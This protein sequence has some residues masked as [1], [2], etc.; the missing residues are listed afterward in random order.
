[1]PKGTF[2]FSNLATP[3]FVFDQAAL[4][5]IVSL[6]NS[7]AEYSNVKVLYS[8]KASVAS[9]VLESVL[10][11]IH[12]V[13]CSSVFE[14]NLLTTMNAEKAIQ[15]ISP[16]LTKAF[17]NSL[18][19]QPDLLTFNSIEQFNRLV[20]STSK[21]TRHAIRV[22]P[23]TQFVKN[24]KYDPCRFGSKLGVN[25]EKIIKEFQHNDSFRDRI[26]GLHVHNNCESADFEQLRETVEILKP[27]LQPEFGLD[28]INLGGGYDFFDADPA[29]FRDV[30]KELVD[31]F[32]LE[33]FIEPGGGVVREAGYLVS[34]IVDMFDSDGDKVAILD[35]TVNHAPEV[36]EYAWSPPVF[37]SVKDSSHQYTL[38]GCSCLAGDVFGK[39]KFE[40]PLK[41]GDKVVFC[42]LGAY[43]MPKW[44]YFNGINLPTI[45]LLT[46]DGDLILKKSFTFE[47][48]A[49]RCGVEKIAFN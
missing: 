33:V 28:W 7:I 23:K 27:I 18:T 2:D 34:T 37:G 43:A 8:L 35:T 22:N 40:N 39:Y 42:S 38:A 1:M 3:A 10:P 26:T 19:R 49:S 14:A 47:E 15:I 41:V 20:E 32:G 36:F 29:P 6:V 12:G 30:V 11:H 21:Q 5:E 24:E 48:F 44:S 9:G 31:E 45:Y 16:G 4:A 13:S 25:V 46:K 17:L